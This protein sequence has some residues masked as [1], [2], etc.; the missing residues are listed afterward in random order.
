ML[1]QFLEHLHPAGEGHRV[2]RRGEQVGQHQVFDGAVLL[3]GLVE[4][5]GLLLAARLDVGRVEDLL[6]DLGMDGELVM[7][8][9]Q[10]L[11]AR[12]HRPVGGGAELFQHLLDDHVVLLE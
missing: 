2:R 7:D 6:F 8:P 9:V 10:Q 1:Q 3:L 5:V 4:H 12:L 11:G